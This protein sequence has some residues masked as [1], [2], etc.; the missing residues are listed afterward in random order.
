M[1][2]FQS[3]VAETNG[4]D[5]TTSLREEQKRFTRE[6]LVDAAMQVFEEVGFRAA[7]I[8]QIA[9]RAGANRS[10]FYLHFKSK[11]ELGKAMAERVTPGTVALFRR[12]NALTR[13]PARRDDLRAWLDDFVSRHVETRAITEVLMEGINADRELSREN[14][15]FF[16]RLTTRVMSDYLAAFPVDRRE[17]ARLKLRLI[18]FMITDLCQ[19][20]IV[21]SMT[22]PSDATLDAACDLLW[23]NIFETL[24]KKRGSRSQRATKPTPPKIT[25]AGT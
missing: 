6:R 2:S 23:A 12:L 13:G 21:Q 9:K 20:E 8:E 17:A 19:R 1:N 11:A 7:S 22:L 24:P 14:H 16:D 18:I 5:P 25:G 15:A 4:G 10:T 3:D